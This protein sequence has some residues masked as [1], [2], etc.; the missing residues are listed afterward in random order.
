VAKY[1]NPLIGTGLAGNMFPGADL[2]F[3]M[4][5]WSPEE[6]AGDPTQVVTAGGYLYDAT[7]IR[8]FA[9]THLSGTG[10]KGAFGDIPFFPYVGTVQSSPSSD[11]TDATY[12][13]TFSHSNELA[14][15]GYYK[16]GLDS[17]VTVE[18]TATARTGS[19]RFT[20]PP[21]QTASM[22]I[23]TSSSEV[24]SE[25][26]QT[27]IDP[28]GVI[29]GSVTSGNFCGYIGTEDR[30][31]YYTLYFQAEF[32]HPFASVGTWQ[33]DSL[34]PGSASTAGG[35]SYDA[36]GYPAAGQGSG[37]YVVLDTSSSP[38][39]NV[40]VGISF[41]SQAN[42][43]ANLD[44]ENP[45]GTSF[46][47]VRQ[48]AYAAWNAEL[49][50]IDVTASMAASSDRLTDFY[51]AL[52]HSLLHPNVFSDVNGQYAGM[53]GQMHQVSGSQKAQY[54]NYSG[55]DTYRSQ[56]QLVTL[57]EPSIGAD[58]AQSLLNQATQNSGV[59]DRWT[60][61]GGGT[62]VMT[63]DPAHA[64]V[65]SI[66]AFGGTSFDAM[67]ALTSMVHAAST[68]TADDTSG[69]GGPIMVRGERPSL[70]EYLSL[71]YV[72]AQ[73]TAWGGAAETLEEVA[74]DFGIAQLAQRLGDTTN[75]TAFLARSDYW[76]NLWNP[77]A[78]GT[79]VGYLDVR[80]NDGSWPGSFDPA[81]QSGFIEDSAA[82]YGWN[83]PFNEGDLI[84]LMGGA[85]SASSRLDAFF[86]PNGQWALQA[87]SNGS[88]SN[89]ADLANEPGL[90]APFVYY[91]VGAPSKTQG[92]LNQVTTTLWANDPKTQAFAQNDDLGA[93]SSWHVWTSIGLF[94][95]W[96]GRA[97]LLATGP[98]LSSV[99]VRRGGGATLTL[100][101]PMAETQPYVTALSVNGH[102]Q[103]A[104]WLPESF[105]ASGGQL[106]FTM[107][108]QA[109]GTWGTGVSDIPPSFHP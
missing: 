63:G 105:V 59:W 60:H 76:K 18:L 81:S 93:I 26:A 57:L 35:T 85:A 39:V 15:A 101:A 23:R 11:M 97:E 94:P 91:F 87:T 47:T 74:A 53:D 103:T 52:Y 56:L 48:S 65:S 28:S 24:G 13:S 5:Q 12:S 83:V 6:T 86:Q 37:G 33:N 43:K 109:G 78:A 32:D 2:P 79:G 66:Y 108:A 17:G 73:G 31:S 98:Q 100:T 72:S 92:V 29:T 64:A 89:H 44:A 9:L 106:E 46:D 36:N 96:P 69:T 70:D 22:L 40:R 49:G 58:I 82:V 41:V 8:G 75:Y 34:A 102:D 20:F 50:R 4:V 80:N 107:A 104:S 61:A 67:G 38:V 42:A 95:M 84:N 51:T 55:W 90:W 45:S 88:G 19:G 3:G 71:H 7:T 14:Q 68:V 21:G 25:N 77:N 16:V 30:R 27:S 62:H 10:C 99:V 1:V 54:A